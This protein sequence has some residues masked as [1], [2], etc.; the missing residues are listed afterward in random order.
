MHLSNPSTVCSSSNSSGF[1]H[2]ANSIS[3]N[4]NSV[5]VS[6]QGSV[7][8]HTASS[9]HAPPVTS[10]YGGAMQSS[11]TSPHVHMPGVPCGACQHRPAL[12]PH[13]HMIPAVP[14][15]FYGGIQSQLTTPFIRNLYFPGKYLY[16]N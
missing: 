8:Y 6:T 5:N 9:T 14:D 12:P 7:S 4:T 3:G 15:N 11:I 2:Y 13:P 16:H 1:T 10:S